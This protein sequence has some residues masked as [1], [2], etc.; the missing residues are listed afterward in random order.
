MKQ[1]Y[2]QIIT[3][4]SFLFIFKV[5]TAAA[6]VDTLRVMVYNTLDYGSNCQ[7]TDSFLHAQL[8]NTIGFANPDLI[9]FVKMQSIQLTDTDHSGI[10]VFGFPDSI[11]KY[12]LDP[13]FPGRFN[14][15]TLTNFSGSN[16][17]DVLFYNQNKLGFVSVK[18]LTSMYF[19]EDF[20][21]YKLYY[22]DPYLG[23]THDSTFLYVVLN[24]TESGSAS[25]PRDSQ[26]TVVI[27]ALKNTFYHLPNLISMGDFNTR[28]SGE[29]GYLLYTATTD[30][31]FI[32]YDPPFNPDH[33]LNY[34][35]D[36]DQNPTDCPSY[37]NTSTRSSAT[38]PN[39]CGVGGGAKDWYQH[40]FLSG[41][42]TDNFDYVKYIPDSYT[43]I[44]NDGKR[45][46]LS[47]NDSTTQVKNTSAPSDVI[48]SIFEFSDK[49]PVML[50]LGITNDSLGNGPANPVIASINIIKSEEKEMMTVNNPVQKDV[51]IHFS[52][53]SLGE[54]CVMN[55]FDIYGRNLFSEEF[56][57]SSTSMNIPIN[58]IP[59]IYILRLQTEH[60][61]N[62]FHIV[63]P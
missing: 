55:C 15:C 60:S 49:Y 1:K 42:I 24:H 12:A 5:I 62:V 9:G 37:L 16:S 25:P 45:I 35:I 33:K 61:I 43:T 46:G 8:K 7:G 29:P 36:W 22:K 40:I 52:D 59:G 10:S 32:F 53:A 30:T 20:D 38:Y 4:V 17:M 23:T 18:T 50:K 54:K 2:L 28:S 21:L 41:W 51:V 34:P 26:D 3:C 6:Q 57:V 58:L 13:N 56:D 39:S 19:A 48:N 27:N 11:I 63:V 44:G 14:Y 31:S 47:V